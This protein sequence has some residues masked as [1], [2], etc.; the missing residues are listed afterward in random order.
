MVIRSPAF[1]SLPVDSRT[2]RLNGAPM[3]GSIPRHR[4]PAYW[5]PFE[6]LPYSPPGNRHCRAKARHGLS[7]QG[8]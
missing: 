6:G 5:T 3:G 8:E 2:T 7:G 4:D 1:G